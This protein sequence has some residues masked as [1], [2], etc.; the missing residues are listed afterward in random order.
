MAEGILRDK[1]KNAG[2]DWEIDSAGTLGR[3]EGCAPHHFA[4]K[5]A[6]Q[7]KIDICEHKCRYFTKEDVKN[8]DKIY[9][10]DDEN[11]LD[12][13]RISGSMWD[14][15]KVELILNEL[16]PGEDLIVPD[17][18]SGGEEGF[19]KVYDML[20]KACEAII[21]KYAPSMHSV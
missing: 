3:N 4:Q 2:L 9:V 14:S 1:V 13:K 11:Y 5:V 18:W 12:V 7:Y 10:M 16:Y 17:P 15:G 8:F 21:K 19:H 6:M 20:D